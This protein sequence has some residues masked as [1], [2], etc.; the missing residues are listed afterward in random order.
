MINPSTIRTRSSA[1]SSRTQHPSFGSSSSSRELAGNFSLRF[2]V[3]RINVGIPWE[4]KIPFPDQRT[5]LQVVWST[6]HLLS[7]VLAGALHDMYY[8]MELTTERYT[9]CYSELR[10]MS[11]DISTQIRSSLL[12]S[13][14][15]FA[16]STFH[17][18]Q[19]IAFLRGFDLNPR[20]PAQYA[21]TMESAATIRMWLVVGTISG[22]FSRCREIGSEIGSEISSAEYGCHYHPT[23][24]SAY[25]YCS[26]FVTQNSST[27]CCHNYTTLAAAHPSGS[28]FGMQNSTTSCCHHHPTLATSYTSTS[29]FGWYYPTP[30]PPS[31][32]LPGR[33]YPCQG[34]R[35]FASTPTSLSSQT[36]T[37]ATGSIFS[38]LQSITSYNRSI[39][40]CS[41][42]G[43]V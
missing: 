35:V 12:D 6:R 13:L 30:L 34:C 37:P 19:D 8:R 5:H 27:D 14:T 38:L 2:D 17:R 33:I 43:S 36:T 9:Q 22:P 26:V 39:D 29:S 31:I 3:L 4:R 15:N 40:G 25:P 16:T 11:I 21:S 24:A 7:H 23:M 32:T 41:L 28:I 20:P 1:G 10:S 42:Q 18:M